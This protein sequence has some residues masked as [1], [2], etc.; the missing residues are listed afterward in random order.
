MIE[1]EQ[2]Q[3]VRDFMHDI[4]QSIKKSN[5]IFRYTFRQQF[6]VRGGLNVRWITSGS[7]G[8]S[9]KF[10][11]YNYHAG[12]VCCVDNSY[13]QLCTFDF[14][15]TAV[16]SEDYPSG[17]PRPL[18][19]KKFRHKVLK[20]VLRFVQREADSFLMQK[21]LQEALLLQTTRHVAII[22]SLPLPTDIQHIVLRKY[23][24][25]NDIVL[26]DLIIL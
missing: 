18:S 14:D 21:R 13:A 5:P 24:Q 19:I 25:E 22:N 15:Q 17:S 26:H 20:R 23:A 6:Q 2:R 4:T 9:V 1:S 7:T 16:F 8:D 12:L 10:G 11:I 3:F